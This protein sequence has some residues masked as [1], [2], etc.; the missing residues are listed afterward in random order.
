M[1]IELGNGF[2]PDLFSSGGENIE[3]SAPPPPSARLL[4]IIFRKMTSVPPINSFHQ[5]ERSLTLYRI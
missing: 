2:D 3:I 4:L 1:F 5:K